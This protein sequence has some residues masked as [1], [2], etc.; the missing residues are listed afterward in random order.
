[1]CCLWCA[2]MMKTSQCP[3][4]GRL[5]CTWPRVLNSANDAFQNEIIN[6]RSFDNDENDMHQY[7]TFKKQYHFDTDITTD[8][9]YCNSACLSLELAK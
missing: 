1:M 7:S 3:V 4:R 5:K 8:I 6:L 2:R 9:L